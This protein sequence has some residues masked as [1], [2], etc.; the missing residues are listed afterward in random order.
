MMLFVHALLN[1]E[2]DSIFCCPLEIYLF[3]PFFFFLIM[4]FTKSNFQNL[5]PIFGSNFH[6][7]P[8]FPLSFSGLQRTSR[9]A[10]SINQKWTLLTIMLRQRVVSWVYRFFFKNFFLQLVC[11][12]TQVIKIWDLRTSKW[13]QQNFIRE[14]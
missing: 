6:F 1:L 3:S 14:L 8:F 9:N 5:S 13:K 7:W 11:T 10:F 12:V 2:Y 4:E